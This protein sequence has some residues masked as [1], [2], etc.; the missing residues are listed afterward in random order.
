MRTGVVGV[1]ASPISAHHPIVIDLWMRSQ[2]HGGVEVEREKT[3]AAETG[4][5]AWIAQ[6]IWCG[7]KGV[8]G[9]TVEARD[10]RISLT[11]VRPPPQM[12]QATIAFLAAKLTEALK[13]QLTAQVDRD[14]YF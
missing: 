3:R 10:S 5:G 6:C 7:G 12:A 2:S 4:S 9:K 11:T 13:Q 1:A 8:G 14:G